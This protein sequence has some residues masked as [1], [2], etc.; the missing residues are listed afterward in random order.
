MRETT[1]QGIPRMVEPLLR[2]AYTVQQLAAQR[3]RATIDLPLQIDDVGDNQFGGS[4][5][6]RRAQVCDKIANG[7]I[8]F[9]TDSR[10]DWHCGME[11]RTRDDLFI[12]LPQIFNAT[13][14]A[15]DHDEIDRMKRLVRC[16]E[17]ANRHCNFLRCTCSLHPHRVDQNLQP[18]C[19]TTEHV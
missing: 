11:Y 8:D 3:A 7:E 5:W 18:R 17:L 12:E 4:A 6:G 16:G 13:T 9:V 14:T 19:A 15:R 1:L 2:V 10:D